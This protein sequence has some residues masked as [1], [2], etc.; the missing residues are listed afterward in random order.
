MRS[1]F[2]IFFYL[3]ANKGEFSDLESMDVGRLL[4]EADH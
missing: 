1:K 2:N 4:I 3:I